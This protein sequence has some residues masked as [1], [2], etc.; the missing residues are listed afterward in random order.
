MTFFFWNEEILQQKLMFLTISYEKIS[1]CIQYTLHI[2]H[3]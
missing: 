1:T 2:I 3:I